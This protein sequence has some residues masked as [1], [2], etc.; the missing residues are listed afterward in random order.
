MAPAATGAKKQKKKWSKG[1]GT[2]A[3][4]PIHAH[5]EYTANNHRYHISPITKIHRIS[6]RLI[7]TSSN[8]RSA[9]PERRALLHQRKEQF[10]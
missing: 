4:S 1:K 9:L 2:H 10:R 7:S 6:K 5:R 8:S 3:S